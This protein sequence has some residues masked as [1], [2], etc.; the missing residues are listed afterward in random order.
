[1]NVPFQKNFI[2]NKNIIGN[3]FLICETFFDK[4][5][6]PELYGFFNLK[7]ILTIYPFQLLDNN[8]YDKY[9][10]EFGNIIDYL[11]KNNINNEDKAKFIDE[12]IIKLSKYFNILQIFDFLS[13]VKY[14]EN[15]SLSQFKTLLGI[16]SS[17]YLYLTKKN[18]EDTTE[19]TLELM[20]IY[21]SIMKNNE[22]LSLNQMLRIFILLTRRRF[23]FYQRSKLL[24]L[25]PENSKYSAY[26][27][28][29]EFNIKEIKNINEY[30]RFFSGYLQMDSYILHNYFSND[31]SYSF[32][33]EPLFILQKHLESNYE[34]FLILEKQ[35]N[36]IIAWT[37]PDVQITIINEYNLF[38]RTAIK[39]ISVIKDEKIRK[40]HAFGISIVL[41]HEKNSY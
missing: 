39:N 31:D 1:M 25:K 21:N 16:I 18:Q 17:Y 4:P 28:A 14:D 8:I 38:Q 36:N 40:N 7:E 22:F 15:I 29:Q 24:I 30:S 3:S 33:I 2:Q 20:A 13:N 10:D 11:S 41:R 34:G 37:E 32:I 5:D 27:E 19:N 6:I 35:N 26:Y 23:E 9:Y 12:C